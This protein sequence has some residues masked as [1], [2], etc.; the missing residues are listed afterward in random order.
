MASFSKVISVCNLYFNPGNS[1]FLSAKPRVDYML[2]G[3][4][5]NEPVYL[6]P[7]EAKKKFRIDDFAQIAQYVAITVNGNYRQKL[8]SVGML[9]DSTNVC[10][11][12]LFWRHLTMFPLTVF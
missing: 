7:V 9:I 12:F 4:L 8:I 11:V 5:G 10:F 2:S 3:F 6:I 1:S